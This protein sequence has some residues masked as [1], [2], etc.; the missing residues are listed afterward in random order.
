MKVQDRPETLLIRDIDE[1]TRENFA[2]IKKMFSTNSNTKVVKR[3]I[4]AY[5][6]KVARLEECE[7]QLKKQHA[8]IEELE[9]IILSLK[10]AQRRVAE[11]NPKGC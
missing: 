2:T 4:N 11:F 7:N 1:D 3:L 5:P 6:D 10:L 9:G 8:Y